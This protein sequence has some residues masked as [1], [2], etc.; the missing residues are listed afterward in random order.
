MADTSKAL[1][2]SH[3]L[4]TDYLEERMGYLR[5]G[6]QSISNLL[7]QHYHLT[8]YVLQQHLPRDLALTLAFS[9]VNYAYSIVQI[10]HS[11]VSEFDLTVYM[12]VRFVFP[13]LCF[14]LFIIAYV[15]QLCKA[16][17]IGYAV[18]KYI[19]YIY[20][21]FIYNDAKIVI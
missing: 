15:F 5:T 12:H 1:Q 4:K 3:F 19:Y 17:T 2:G 9:I 8:T 7:K 13:V 18:F 21:I 16:L 6:F 20:H 14:K 10:F 11:P